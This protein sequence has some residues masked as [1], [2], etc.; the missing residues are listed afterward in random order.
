MV[1]WMDIAGASWQNGCVM[2]GNRQGAGVVWPRAGKSIARSA[3]L[4]V[5]ARAGILR[6]QERGVTR[7]LQYT[8]P[9]E[10]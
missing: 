8:P 10:P 7:A 2:W 9:R 5:P 1:F 6:A 3:L 4:D